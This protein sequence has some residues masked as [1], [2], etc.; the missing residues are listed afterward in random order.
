[1]NKI[2]TRHGGLSVMEDVNTRYVSLSLQG[3]GAKTSGDQ[4]KSK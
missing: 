2:I 1:M 4:G 3:Y